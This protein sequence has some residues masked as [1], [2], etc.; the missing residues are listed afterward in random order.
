MGTI[1]DV[2]E[3]MAVEAALADSRVLLREI[4][5]AVPA[6]ISV[7]DLE[8]RYVFA[9]A[10]LANF[11][12]LPVDWFPGH[13]LAE[14]YGD[15]YLR[16]ILEADRQVIETGQRQ[17]F[18][19]SDYR[20]PDGQVSTWLASRA[21]IRDAAGKVKY[22][23]SVGLDI[24]GQRQM[25]AALRESEDRFRSIADSLPALIWMS[26]QNGQCI[27]LNKQWSAYTGRPAAEE[28]GRGFFDSIHP[29]DRPR[30]LEV[31]HGMLAYRGHMTDEYR[32]RGK[33]GKYRWFLDTLVP[34]FSA[35]GT[36]L[37][38]IGV[39]I[40][41]EDRRNLEEKLRHVQRL[42][43]VGH[44]AGGIAH[45]FN[46]L[47]TVVIGNLDLIQSNPRD[48]EKVTRLSTSALQDAER[49]AELVHRMVAFSR[50]QTLNPLR[51]D[52]N[53]L[54][55]R[56]S[57]MLRPS[58]SANIEIELKLAPEPCMAIAD[59]GQVEDSL[60][61]LALNARDAMPDGGKITIGTAN[62]TLDS[63]YAARDWDVKPGPYVMISVTDT[64]TGMT[65]EVQ[66]QAVQPFFTT[67]E[68]GKG[69]GLGLSMV[70]GFVKQ[71]GGHLDIY[72][73]VG[74]GTTVKLYLPRSTDGVEP[75]PKPDQASPTGG[76][77]TILV[78]EDD[79]LV[80]RYVVEQLR[81]LGYQILEA[82]TGAAALALAAEGRHFDLLFTD[83][84]LPGGMLGPELLEEMHRRLPGLRALF[85]SG[86]SE[87]HVLPR[88]RR[89]G[90][91]RLLQK[92]YNRQRLAEEIRAALDAKAG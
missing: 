13:A 35:D 52:L 61:N 12:N 56:M 88:E 85:S 32:L 36:Y 76:S 65:P 63:G 4:I 60:L 11:H 15:E 82:G 5:D 1:Q 89:A 90:S 47:L 18:Y 22:V 33:N 83:V 50:Q 28:L 19:R 48:T 87:D 9:N 25:E 27:F 24:T 81:G 39:L 73:E 78:V 45:D 43:V 68:V 20:A 46:N 16:H 42:E 74:R 58:L 3:Q 72:S 2:T 66:A 10:A 91:V 21:P 69:S 8:G 17:G 53:E 51:L 38:H 14:L 64:G 75:P 40:D 44:L 34:R 49:G 79:E 37:G 31:E 54:V 7:H 67:K 55:A 41:I 86:Y 57:Q 30:S 6:T 62:V 23:V 80:R 26:D 92:P 70:Y 59:A 71:S 77:E 84:M 29:E